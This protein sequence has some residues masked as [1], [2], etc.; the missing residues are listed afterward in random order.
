MVTQDSVVLPGEVLGSTRSH[1]PGPG[2]HVHNDKIL[3]SIIGF[4]I[5][6][7]S[8]SNNSKDSGHT[9][10]IHQS[11]GK[12]SKED[13]RLIISVSAL[14][15]TSHPGPVLPVV[16]DYVYGRVTTVT[17]SQANLEIVAI[18]QAEL[19]TGKPNIPPVQTAGMDEDTTITLTAPASTTPPQTYQPLAIALRGI[20]RS[21]DVRMTEKDRVKM[22]ASVSV[23]DIVRAA[24][25]G[26]GDQG[27]YF[28]STAGNEL[29][30]VMAWS[31]RGN[32]C[33]PLSWCEVGDVV[34]GEREGRKVAK[35]I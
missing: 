16:G 33:V 25:V 2:T 28:L 4:V 23:G 14:S 17:R 6:A 15:T 13:S 12:Q 24:V 10:R 34:T 29:G 3:S 20:L 31:V 8:P 1:V 11:G 26:I 30:V 27:G 21:Q 32:G 7:S 18:S 22:S 35:P 5:N 19:V 9:R